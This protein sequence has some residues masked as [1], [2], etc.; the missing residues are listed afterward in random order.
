MC[1]GTTA[2]QLCAWCIRADADG[3]VHRYAEIA[4]IKD[5]IAAYRV[6]NSARFPVGIPRGSERKQFRSVFDCL[7][8]FLSGA[9]I[10][11]YHETG[12]QRVS[13]EHVK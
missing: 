3:R 10:E 2:V 9:R 6:S 7:L 8:L 4:L 5:A 11:F 13:F 1:T 12:D